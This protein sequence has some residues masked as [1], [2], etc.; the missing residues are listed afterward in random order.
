MDIMPFADKV[1]RSSQRERQI[2]LKSRQIG[3]TEERALDGWSGSKWNISLAPLSITD[4]NTLM[5]FLEGKGAVKPFL[6][7]PCKGGSY[8]VLRV[9]DSLKEVRYNGKYRFSFELQEVR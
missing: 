5:T 8:K 6:Y 3:G 4:R 7:N 9:I 2:L 1:L